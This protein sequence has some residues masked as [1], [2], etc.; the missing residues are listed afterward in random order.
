MP[1]PFQLRWLV[2][3]AAV[4]I[5]SASFAQVPTFQVIAPESKVNFKVDA[6]VSIA[7]VFEKWTANL[8]FA[9]PYVESGVL[10]IIVQ[11]ASV[12]AGSSLKEGKLK[13]G[14]FFDVKA[15]PEITFRSK[16]IVQTAPDAY[17][18]IGDF[19]IRGLTKEETLTVNYSPDKPDEGRIRGLMVFDRK[20]YGMTH[21]IPLVHI[22][23]RVEVNVDMKIHRT[24][25]PRPIQSAK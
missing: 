9:T 11:A 3:A 24:S 13:G 12:N 18:I 23:D 17:S 7:G 21:G 15:N 25:G 1:F 16:K 20:Q 2:L 14:D 6:S 4:S 22:A 5:P 19:T 8:R 10:E